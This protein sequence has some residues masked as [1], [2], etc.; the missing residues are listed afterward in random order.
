M[1]R[2]FFL[3][4]MLGA[5]PLSMVAQDDLY[6]VPKKK[7]TT[8]STDRYGLPKDT[9]Y[10][11]S[12]RS[13]DEYNRRK[14]TYEVIENDS[15]N[16][17]ID[18][19]AV[20]G[21]YPDSIADEDFKLTKK[22]QR[23]DDYDI[24]NN[25]AFWS[26]YYAGR[27][28]YWGWYSPWYYRTYGWYG[29]WYDPWYYGS[30]WYWYDPWYWDTAF[31]YNPLYGWNRYSWWN[32]GYYGGYAPVVYAVGPRHHSNGNTGSIDLYRGYMNGRVYTSGGSG[33]RGSFAG[34]GGSNATTR[35]GSS[36]TNSLRSQTVGGHRAYDSNRGTSSFNSNRGSHVSSS[37]RSNSSSYSSSGFSGGSRSSGGSFSGGGGGG[38]ARSGGGGGGGHVGGRR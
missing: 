3:S 31:W 21:V 35:L 38:G 17:I 37:N 8:Q 27:N 5:L 26:G 34:R 4:I 9:Y 11:G 22:M 6:F 15:T 16:D 7:S 33:G 14:S 25:S 20:K 19:S 28:S 36:R 24:S 13:V 30:S 23:F 18:F 29:G 10:A 1:K 12:S 2:F 32:Y